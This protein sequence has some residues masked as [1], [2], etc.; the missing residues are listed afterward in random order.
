MSRE[1]GTEWLE[2]VN[3]AAICHVLSP[4]LG[5]IHVGHGTWGVEPQV[6]EGKHGGQQKKLC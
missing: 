1:G 3:M 2:K 6:G 4:Y 5:Y